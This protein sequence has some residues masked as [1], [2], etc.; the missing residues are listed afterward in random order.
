MIRW[1]NLAKRHPRLA[2]HKQLSAVQPKWDLLVLNLT[3][4]SRSFTSNL[5]EAIASVNFQVETHFEPEWK[6]GGYLINKTADFNLHLTRFQKARLVGPNAPGF[7]ALLVDW[8]V[9]GTTGID[10]SKTGIVYVTDPQTS[11]G[12]VHLDE[13]VA[14][15]DIPFALVGARDKNWS[16][17]LSHEVLELLADPWGSR[18]VHYTSNTPLTF[19]DESTGQTTT[20]LIKNQEWI[21]EVC[22][23]IEADEDGYDIAGVRVSDFIGQKYYDTT[24]T[25]NI[26]FRSLLERKNVPKFPFPIN[27]GGY[28]SF[29]DADTNDF[30]QITWFGDAKEATYVKLDL[31]N[32]KHVAKLRERVPHVNLIFKYWNFRKRFHGG[33]SKL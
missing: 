8:I 4:R 16:V 10:W 6:V 9:Q 12:G 30:Y 21:V 7:G 13:K 18:F 28:L 33:L 11:F 31:G 22:D 26:D 19:T 15:L 5:D 25:K 1:L 2:H 23:S 27:P 17:V 20:K 14:S 29:F 24:V 3:D 32:E